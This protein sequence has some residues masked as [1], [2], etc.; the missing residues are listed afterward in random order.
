MQV[1]D[2]WIS[3]ER[4]APAYSSLCRVARALLHSCSAHKATKLADLDLIK[5]KN[6]KEDIHSFFCSRFVIVVWQLAMIEADSA[7]KLCTFEQEG[8]AEHCPL[9]FHC[10]PVVSKYCTPRIC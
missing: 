7:A 5:Y 1:I 3:A 6:R 8:D 10:M 9:L 4:Q 2:N